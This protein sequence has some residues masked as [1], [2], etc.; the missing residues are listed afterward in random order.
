[1]SMRPA[2][3]GTGGPGSDCGDGRRRTVS[4]A[5]PPALRALRGPVSLYDVR[6]VYAVAVQGISGSARLM[7]LRAPRSSA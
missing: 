3:L 5:P 4:K 6:Q 7:T 1:M 2:T